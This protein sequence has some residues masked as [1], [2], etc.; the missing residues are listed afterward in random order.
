MKLSVR[1]M[2]SPRS[3]RPVPNQFVIAVGDWEFLQSYQALVARKGPEGLV[4]GP[5]WDY[6]RTTVRYVTQFTGR[7]TAKELRREIKAGELPVED[8][9]LP[10]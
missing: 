9:D 4:L 2:R 7:S 5:N 10:I 8:L 6:S 3:G 1:N